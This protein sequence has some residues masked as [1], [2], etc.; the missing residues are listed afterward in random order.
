VCVDAHDVR[1]TDPD[2]RALC[3]RQSRAD[4]VVRLAKIMKARQLAH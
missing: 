1:Y 2:A 4:T 3:V